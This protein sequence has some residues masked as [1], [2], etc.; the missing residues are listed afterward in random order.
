MK[1]VGRP[2]IKNQQT[3]LCANKTSPYMICTTRHKPALNVFVGNTR[4]YMLYSVSLQLAF[5]SG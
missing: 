3:F 2:A 4:H 5:D 1:Q